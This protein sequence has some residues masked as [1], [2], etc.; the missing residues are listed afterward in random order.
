MTKRADTVSRLLGMRCAL[1]YDAKDRADLRRR[2]AADFIRAALRRGAASAIVIGRAKCLR[3]D[4]LPILPKRNV[5]VLSDLKTYELEDRIDV[6]VIDEP[7]TRGRNAYALRRW[8]AKNNP[9]FRV[10]LMDKPMQTRMEH[11]WNLCALVVNAPFGYSSQ[12]KYLKGVYTMRQS[13][14][15]PILRPRKGMLKA[16]ARDAKQLVVEL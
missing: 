6:V 13:P 3:E 2:V 15:G 9:P 7:R 1:I 14:R 12:L 5:T 8:L 16:I 11:A 10:V 4:W